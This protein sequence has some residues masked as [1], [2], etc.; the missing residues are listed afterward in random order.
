MAN[1]KD[2]Q[3]VFSA[4]LESQKKGSKLKLEG[5]KRRKVENDEEVMGDVI[6]N[7]EVV[8]DPEKSV[9]DLENT[10]DELQDII[11]KTPEGENAVSDEYVGDI[12]YACPICGEKFFS[13]K[14]YTDGDVC[15]ICKAEP[16]DGFVEYGVVAKAEPE[17]VKDMAEVDE[18]P[19]DDKTE[20][21]VDDDEK[22]ESC[23]KFR[24][25]RKIKHESTEY[26]PY[27]DP[28]FYW[29]W[30]A[31]DLYEDAMKKSIPELEEAFD[32]ILSLD[33]AEY[34]VRGMSADIADAI[35]DKRHMQESRKVKRE[36]INRRLRKRQV[37]RR[38]IKENDNPIFNV[39]IDIATKEIEPEEVT[40]EPECLN[41]ELDE[42]SFDEA[43]TDFIE[44]NYKNSCKKMKVVKATYNTKDD[45][46]KL[47]CRIFMKN[48]KVKPVTLKL[49]EAKCQ[50]NS[51]ILKGFDA[52]NAFKVEGKRAPFIFKVSRCGN[53]IKC[54]GL[55][56]SYITTHDKVGRVK[57]EGIARTRK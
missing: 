7:I 45:A 8:T 55:S 30:D 33:M 29:I 25:S 19:E 39:D 46:L 52:S 22:V 48:G 3:A 23:R 9:D 31:K 24:K 49:K 6:D 40:V 32:Y 28:K 57:V 42:E 12:I 10:A 15:P 20:I 2:T 27:E 35:N 37:S 14:E 16:S 51:A 17:E 21:E 13:E 50:G 56:Y 11:D 34:L 1:S 26:D 54:E 18:E 4:L 41:C 43:L 53:K 47:E 5:I 38:T 36:A 44:E